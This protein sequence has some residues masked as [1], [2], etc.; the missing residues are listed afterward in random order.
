M[1]RVFKAKYSWTKPDGTRVHK[2]T[3]HWYI[4]FSDANKRC[5]RRKAGITKEQAQDALRKAEWEVLNEKNG[6]PTQ[7]MSDI[8]V[9]DL[10]HGYLDAKR[11][12]AT[13]GY[14][15]SVE[16]E[17]KRL[18]DF[19]RIRLL[20]ELT[21]EAVEK[22]MA[23]RLDEGKAARTVECVLSSLKA[24]LNWAVKTRRIPYNPI[25]CVERIHGEARHVRRALSEEE[26]AQLLVAAF[27]GPKRR[28]IRSRYHNRPRKDGTYKPLEI[29]PEVQAQWTLEGQNNVLAYRIMLETG[30]RRSE[31]RSLTWLDLDLQS[32][33]FTTRPHWQGNKNG[34]EETLP[35][36]PGLL[37]ALRSWRT[38]RSGPENAPVVDISD[39]LLRCFNDD[40]IAAKIPKK[41]SAGRVID[42]H[43]LR[44]TFGTRLGRTPG[45]D[46]KSVQTLMRHSDPRM[47]F[48]VYV[49][50]DTDRLKSVAAMLPRI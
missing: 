9:V 37:E 3:K 28:G 36:T 22:Y 19:I 42:L 13:A 44:H 43:A 7:R 23:S 21:P 16:W 24:C 6:L 15:K 45:A 2:T 1:G 26:I 18:F 40:L 39:R 32:G 46:P 8:P 4:Q 47:T 17:L 50:S 14:L 11:H 41:D 25:A 34:K 38:V 12:R 35:L 29:G 48:G 5:I 33:T 27:D 31:A 49:H 10:M 30:L 20:K